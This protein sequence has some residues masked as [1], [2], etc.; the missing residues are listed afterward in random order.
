VTLAIKN[1]TQQNALVVF[2]S[3]EAASNKPELIIAT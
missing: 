3:D 1:P 2:N